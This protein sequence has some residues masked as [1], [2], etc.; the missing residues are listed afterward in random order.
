MILNLLEF[1]NSFDT[2]VFFFFFQDTCEDA[3]RVAGN[4]YKSKVL[5]RNRASQ[6][7]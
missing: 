6:L 1:A 2:K 7:R 4:N 3:T 5:W